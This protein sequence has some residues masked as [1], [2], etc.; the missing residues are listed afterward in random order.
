LKRW[1][2]A[3]FSLLGGVQSGWVLFVDIFTWKSASGSWTRKRLL[4]KID[5]LRWK[6]SLKREQ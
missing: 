2:L 4:S 3:W 6:G 1:S 5:E